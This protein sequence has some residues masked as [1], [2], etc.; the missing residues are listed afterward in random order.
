LE[1]SLFKTLHELQRIQAMR[2]E[3]KV[4]LPVAVDFQGDGRDL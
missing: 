3:V 1:R 4:T 2:L